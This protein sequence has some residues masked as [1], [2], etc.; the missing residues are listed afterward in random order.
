MWLAANGPGEAGAHIEVRTTRGFAKRI[1]IDQAQLSECRHE[2][3][4]PA[5][6]ALCQQLVDDLA[7]RIRAVVKEAM[8]G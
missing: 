8:R 7:T 2:E 3:G 4:G 1:P 5:G 6:V